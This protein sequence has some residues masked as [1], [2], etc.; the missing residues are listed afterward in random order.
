MLFLGSLPV[1][2]F[3]FTK[4]AGFD[5]ITDI[6]K[7]SIAANNI[8]GIRRQ[9]QAPKLRVPLLDIEGEKDANVVVDFRNVSFAYPARPEVTVLR[10]ISLQ[11]S[12]GQTVAVVGSSGSGK[13]TLLALLERF[14]DARS[15]HINV[16]G[17]PIS[18][19]EA[20][21]YRRRL[22]IVPQEPTLYRG[23]YT[24]QRIYRTSSSPI[25]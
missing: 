25:Y 11:I 21:V 13:S 15:G 9:A 16:F 4:D 1:G 20:D 14:Y 17:K 2:R 22:A 8:L 10:N 3:R 23:P 6:S 18:S 24:R 7:A 12:Q 5:K 19:E